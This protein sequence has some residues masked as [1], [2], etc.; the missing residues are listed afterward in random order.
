MAVADLSDHG[1]DSAKRVEYWTERLR[2]AAERSM[3]P[4]QDA[5]RALREA[6]SAI[7]KRLV[8]RGEVLRWHP[9]ASRFTLQRVLPSL[10][11]E[12]D[13]RI[14]VSAQLIR[15]NRED[16]MRKTLQRFAGWSTSIPTGGSGAVDRREV[17][18]NVGRAL[19]QLKFAERRVAI[20]QG[21]KLTSS[22]SEVVAQGGGAI[23]CRWESQWRQP[24]YDYRED[25][26]ERD[27]RVYLVR[28]SWAA[29]QGLVR[30]DWYDEVTAAGEEPFC[31]CK[32]VWLY[33]LRDLPEDMLTRRGREALRRVAA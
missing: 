28:G 22:I 24:N 25:H 21:H 9:G 30:G 20:D 5:E 13:R 18:K 11:G 10:R 27:G 8:D 14:L 16:A 19:R 7:Y 17:K 3:R 1:F 15:F 29:T 4:L 2:R 31:R 32:A 23:A 26:K 33:T 12:L 6:L